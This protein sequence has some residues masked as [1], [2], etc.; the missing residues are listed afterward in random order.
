MITRRSQTIALVVLV[1]LL[2]GATPLD[3]PTKRV[4]LPTQL[5]LDG[6]Q[7]LELYVGTPPRNVLRVMYDE[8][9][10]TL[11]ML[12]L[13]VLPSVMIP[14]LRV[15]DAICIISIV[16]CVR[17]NEMAIFFSNLARAMPTAISLPPRSGQ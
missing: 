4:T 11:T 8:I 13:F 10:A 3:N 16:S 6:T 7:I 1:A 5:T 12:W 9:S 14:E 15:F 17:S 2:C